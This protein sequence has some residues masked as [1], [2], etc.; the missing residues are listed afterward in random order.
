MCS[1]FGC[2][3]DTSAKR[4]MDKTPS[5]SSVINS[6]L[7]SNSNHQPPDRSIEISVSLPFYLCLEHDIH[8]PS[9]MRRFCPLSLTRPRNHALAFYKP[10][11]DPAPVAH[12]L[13]SHCLNQRVPSRSLAQVRDDRSFSELWFSSAI[14]LAVP[15][16]ALP[17][18]NNGN[19]GLPQPPD[20][21]TLKLGKSKC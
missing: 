6:S 11:A 3:S 10:T 21:R 17:E 12:G 16:Q 5:T 9:P 19:G 7:R 2:R 8:D 13:N 14:P 18:L 20:E 1:G 15:K 4:I